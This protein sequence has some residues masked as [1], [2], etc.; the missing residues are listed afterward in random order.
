[1]DN[2]GR[3]G[4]ARSG[5]RDNL[6]TLLIGRWR[7]LESLGRGGAVREDREGRTLPMFRRRGFGLVSIDT[8]RRRQSQ[9]LRGIELNGRQTSLVVYPS[10]V[11]E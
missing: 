4:G 11:S 5:E 1:M 10:F 2:R 3:G 7:G 9:S 8:L 6:R